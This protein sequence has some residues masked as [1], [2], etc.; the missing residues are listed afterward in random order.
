VRFGIEAEGTAR[1]VEAH[2]GHRPG[3]LVLVGVAFRRIER[4]GDDLRSDEAVLRIKGRNL[5]EFRFVLGLEALILRGG[6]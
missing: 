2:G 3:D 5:A 6:Q 1:R 4:R